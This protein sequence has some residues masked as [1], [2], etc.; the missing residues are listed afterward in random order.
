MTTLR[1]RH[2]DESGMTLIELMVTS[3]ILV[4]LLGMV[5]VSMDLINSVSGSVTSQFQEFNQALPAMAPFHGLLAAEVEPGPTAGDGTPV[6]GFQAIGNFSMT[7][8]ANI[9]TSYNNTTSCPTGPTCTNG[10]TT[11]GPA[12][13]VA[14][15]FDGSG[16]RATTCSP[17]SPAASS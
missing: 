17:A 8:Y 15:E 13:I 6:P 9:G 12:K 7:F 2:F 4:A 14:Q 16:R 1:E 10:G 5:F 11:A 3:T